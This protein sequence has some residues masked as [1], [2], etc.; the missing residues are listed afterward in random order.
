MAAG[1]LDEEWAQG[2]THRFRVQLYNPR[3]D[4]TGDASTWQDF[5]CTF[6]AAH[7]DVDAS[8]LFQVNYPADIEVVPGDDTTIEITIAHTLTTG[9][10]W[11]GKTT[12]GYLD[13]KGRDGDGVPWQ[14]AFGRGR[15]RASVT[16]SG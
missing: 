12:R 1:V 9:A 14:L 16:R 6:K 8:A 2:T 3:T 7:D 13:V 5:W 15:V 10:T 4:E 11:L